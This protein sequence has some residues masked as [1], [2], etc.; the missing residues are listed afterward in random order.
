MSE[1]THFVRNPTPSLVSGNHMYA[2]IAEMAIYDT[3]NQGWTYVTVRMD[4]KC[5]DERECR[6][7]GEMYTERLTGLKRNA[8]CTC[9]N[10]EVT[11][12]GILLT[13]LS[14]DLNS[15]HYLVVQIA[16]IIV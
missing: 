2:C 13:P 14:R 16:R 6:E 1:S 9:Q 11:N 3:T 5:R 12:V 15:S 10:I 4:S 7:L 8:M